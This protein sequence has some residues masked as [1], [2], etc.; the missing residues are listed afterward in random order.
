VLIPPQRLR[1]AAVRGVGRYYVSLEV[2]TAPEEGIWHP[3][4]DI[5]SLEVLGTQFE[6]P[7]E[8]G[9]LPGGLYRWRVETG[10][11]QAEAAGR[12][13]I[14]SERQQV[15]LRGA[16]EALGRSHLVSAAIYRSFGLYSEA[17]AE[18]RP[19]HAA[20]PQQPWLLGRRKTW[21]PTC[22]GR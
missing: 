19:L 16:R 6:L 5:F 15:K 12:F 4:H 17:L 18:L 9:W 7:G 13:R 8:I 14:L 20:E 11:G 3:V 22:A 10:D 2:L 1:W 21:R